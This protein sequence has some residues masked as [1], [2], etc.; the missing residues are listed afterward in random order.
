M[1]GPGDTWE[2]WELEETDGREREREMIA[3]DEMH[4]QTDSERYMKE[5]EMTYDR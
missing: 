1:R 4:R 3:I 2:V 5:R